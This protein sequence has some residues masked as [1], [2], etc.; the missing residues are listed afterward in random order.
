MHEIRCHEYVI[1]FYIAIFIRLPSYKKVSN[2]FNLSLNEKM[3]LWRLHSRH[4]LGKTNHR[5]GDILGLKNG[6][7]CILLMSFSTRVKTITNA[8]GNSIIRYL[9]YGFIFFPT[10]YKYLQSDMY[11]NR[12]PEKTNAVSHKVQAIFRAGFFASETTGSV[13][14]QQVY[15][16]ADW[17]LP[18]SWELVT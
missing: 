16:R 9:P 6:Q 15:A 7:D 1:S 13:H 11:T 8:C 14:R 10:I 4:H 18:V 5:K 17:H 3:K 12:E 2:R